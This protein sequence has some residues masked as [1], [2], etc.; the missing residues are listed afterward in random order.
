VTTRRPVTRFVLT[1][2]ARGEMVR[3]QITAAEVAG[4]L[5]SPDQVVTVRADRVVYQ[6]RT[7]WGEP[8]RT[9]LVRVVVDITRQPVRVV[10]AYRTSKVAKYWRV[11]P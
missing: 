1:E 10:T 9:F 7:E 5:G 11:E 4:V 6:G 8:P 3:R 2:H